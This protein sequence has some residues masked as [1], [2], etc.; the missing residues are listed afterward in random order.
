MRLPRPLNVALIGLVAAVC[1]IA[2]APAA[3]AWQPPGGAVFNYPESSSAARWRIVDT[4]DAAI[5][6]A[7][8]GSRIMVSSFL[9][10]AQR[11]ADAL[12]A[13]KRRG[14]AVQIVLDGNDGDTGQA[15][16]IARV[17]NRDN[18]PRKKGVDKRGILLKWGRDGSF[19]RFCKGTCRGHGDGNNHTKFYLFSHTG[20]AKNVVMV[21]SS[22]LNKGGAG[23]G[24]N[25]M[26][27]MR[28][29]ATLFRDYALIHGQMSLDRNFGR[30]NYR[31]FV[32][33]NVTARFFPRPKGPDPVLRDLRQ[34]RCHGA[35]GGA[36]RNGRTAINISMFAWNNTRGM[37]IARRLVQ[38][39]HNGCYVS[40]VYGAPSAQVRDYLAASARA[41]GVKL[42][43]S[44]TDRDDDGLFDLRVHHKYMLIN[45]VYGGDHSSWRVHTGS[46]NWG[47]GTLRKG[48]E[49]TINIVSRKAY[50]QYIANWDKMAAVS[51]QIGSPREAKIAST[52]PALRPL[53]FGTDAD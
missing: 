47:R 7:H 36:G 37:D 31:Q 15:K 17:L 41:G 45:G 25:D 50:R 3:G 27:I 33:G 13:A 9:M 42:W 40:I 22:N 53:L 5:R 35:N 51:R 18:K 34:V 16:R 8:K 20:T 44:R 52:Q 2:F 19:V 11:S 49:N 23:R 38:L 43:D 29:R 1:T 32:A 46:Q 10:D 30:L 48:D 39:R 28:N 6:H 26:Y 21:S 14:V 12:I 24:W 4:V